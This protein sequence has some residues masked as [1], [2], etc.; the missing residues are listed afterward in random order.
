MVFTNVS[1]SYSVAKI[2]RQRLR[3]PHFKLHVE[4]SSPF[5]YF[6]SSSIKEGETKFKNEPAI[7]DKLN[8]K[9]L[10]SELEIDSIIDCVG[11]NHFYVP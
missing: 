9:L 7:Y 1:N 3:N 2:F 8:K 5:L 11:S 10:L 4:V 6:D